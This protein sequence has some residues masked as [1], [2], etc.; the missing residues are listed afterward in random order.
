MEGCEHYTIAHR[1]DLEKIL[2]LE[3]CSDTAFSQK[4][5]INSGAAYQVT[6]TILFGNEQNRR[7]K[8]CRGNIAWEEAGN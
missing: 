1:Q 3:K 2:D 7:K 5:K 4:I 6:G 8:Y